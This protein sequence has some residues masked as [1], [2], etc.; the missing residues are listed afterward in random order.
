V[1]AVTLPVRAPKASATLDSRPYAFS[2]RWIRGVMPNMAM[3]KSASRPRVIVRPGEVVRSGAFVFSD[4]DDG[5][6]I[7]HVSAVF[8]LGRYFLWE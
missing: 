8:F 2:V 5:V 1:A 4:E 6:L 3:V 7:F